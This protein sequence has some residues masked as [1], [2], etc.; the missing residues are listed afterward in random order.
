MIYGKRG[1]NSAP[2]AWAWLVPSRRVLLTVVSVFFAGLAGAGQADTVVISS[3]EALAEYARE[4]GNNVRMKPGDYDLGDYITP[5]RINQMREQ[6]EWNYIDFSGSD[7]TYDLTG[8]TIYVDTKEVRAALN[9]PQHT[10]EFLVSGD[11]NQIKGLTIRNVGDGASLGGSVLTLQGDNNILRGT[12]LSVRGSRP[13]GYGDLLGKGGRN[14]VGLRKHSAVNIRGSNTRI[15]DTRL[16]MRS[17]G[18]GFYVQGGATD[19]HFENCY[20]E[21]EMRS[22]DEMLAETD[23]P[24]YEH[25]FASV[26]TNREGESRITHGYMKSLAED[27]FRTYH[28]TDATFINCT[29]KNMRAGFELSGDGEIRIENSVSIGNERGFWI[30]SNARVINSRGDAKYGPLLFLE[31][32]DT[33][34]E[35]ELMPETS[36]KIVHALATIHGRNNSVAITPYKGQQRAAPLPIKLGYSQPSAGESMSPYGQ[37][38]ARNIT[39]RNATTMPLIIGRQTYGSTVHTRGEVSENNGENISIH[40]FP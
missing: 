13:Y 19:I 31:G 35:L 15:Y 39:L 12:T 24:A 20:V 10:T 34:V 25:D 26:L 6:K 38:A 21:G 17:F 18:H 32:H 14:I 8:V 5:E 36:D 11:N 16:Y 37:R 3:I 40:S 30:G 2:V 1:W 33:S 27:A 22:T 29:A 23:G 28:S 9:P 4:D 7:N